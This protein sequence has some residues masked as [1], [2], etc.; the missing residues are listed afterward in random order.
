MRNRLLARLPLGKAGVRHPP[1]SRVLIHRV[2]PTG[3]RYIAQ[4]TP[5]SQLIS[6]NEEPR[7]TKPRR[8][9]AKDRAV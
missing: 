7:T 5:V 8:T 2:D 3:R 6:E 9:P 1:G 4:L